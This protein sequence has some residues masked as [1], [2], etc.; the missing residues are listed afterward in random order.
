[1]FPDYWSDFE[2]QIPEA[3]RADMVS[4]Y[5]R[6]LTSSNELEQIQAAKAWS[7]WEGRCATLHPNPSVQLGAKKPSRTS[8]ARRRALTRR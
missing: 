7:V 8:T 5:Y 1:M 4:A 2:A 3:D 6:K